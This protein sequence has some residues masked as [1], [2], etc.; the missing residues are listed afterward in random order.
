MQMDTNWVHTLILF[1]STGT[2]ILNYVITSLFSKFKQHLGPHVNVRSCD[3]HL[4]NYLP[5]FKVSATGFTCVMQQAEPAVFNFSFF[6]IFFKRNS[7]Y[8]NYYFFLFYFVL[9]T[10]GYFLII[11]LIFK[12]NFFI[13]LYFFNLLHK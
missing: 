10:D 5:V 7:L 4:Y 2:A 1:S 9:I 6:L 12:R 11:H 13:H 3:I 8:L